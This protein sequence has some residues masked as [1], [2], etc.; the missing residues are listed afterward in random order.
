MSMAK[1]KI[2]SS[3]KVYGGKGI[4]LTQQPQP[5]LSG[6]GELLAS[7]N[8]PI[9]MA[10]TQYSSQTMRKIGHQDFWLKSVT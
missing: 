9:C 10:K 4:S 2:E 7:K 3:Q 8:Y 6:I 1:N 5:E